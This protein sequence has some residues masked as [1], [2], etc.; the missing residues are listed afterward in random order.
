M[1]KVAIGLMVLA[2]IF[3]YGTMRWLQGGNPQERNYDLKEFTKIE[4]KS[5]FNIV[6]YEGDYDVKIEAEKRVLKRVKVER[7]GDTLKLSIKPS[8]RQLSKSATAYITMPQ[9]ASIS[10]SGAVS[11]R[12]D[13]SMS[14]ADD[15]AVE[16]S[17]A[18]SLV[19]H[20][21]SENI[22]FELSSASGA[23]LSG[24]ASVVDL[25]LTGASSFKGNDFYAT[26]LDVVASG[27][28]DG[29][30]M[31]NEMLDVELS[32]AS[33]LEV[34]G[35]ISQVAAKVSGASSL[36]AEDLRCNIADIEVSGA[37]DVDLTVIE[38]IDADIRSA[39][40]AEIYGNPKIQNVKTS[41]SSDVDFN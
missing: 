27:A 11:Y 19:A 8:L 20:I 7:Y 39:S 2:M 37:S 14:Y 36:K 16:L 9:I 1:K 41:G 33:S 5:G 40:D 28:S 22:D 18:S 24:S 10:G 4:G 25:V 6:I 30:I 26:D 31:V 23:D 3:G 15:V 35:D 21:E 38:A 34:E 12:I 32:G 13:E 17:G 29:D